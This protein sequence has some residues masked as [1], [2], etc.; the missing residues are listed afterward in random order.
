M[1]D[2]IDDSESVSNPSQKKT[3]SI[4]NNS[5][6]QPFKKRADKSVLCVSQ[7]P[8][9]LNSLNAW[10]FRLNLNE[11]FLEIEI[12]SD[13][14]CENISRSHKPNKNG[15]KKQSK[16]SNDGFGKSGILSEAIGKIM[17][18]KKPTKVW[19]LLHS[20]DADSEDELEEKEV[21]NVVKKSKD[22]S[23]PEGIVVSKRSQRSAAS[24]AIEQMSKDSQDSSDDS[25]QISRK[26]LSRQTVKQS[27]LSSDSSKNSKR[28]ATESSS[29]SIPNEE[30][31]LKAQ[32]KKPQPKSISR[33][34]ENGFSGPGSSYKRQHVK[35]SKL[36]KNTKKK[37]SESA[38]SSDEDFMSKPAM[39]KR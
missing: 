37:S 39:K 3:G 1:N 17:E 10:T 20:H 25:E 15:S 24:K 8:P 30:R 34:Q 22:S 36:Q 26:K 38:E 29:D 28:A 35:V 5:S 32:K 21:S 31:S 18:K 12:Q 14:D 6:Q 16:S 13:S 2:S 27:T 7:T 4:L 33:P 11:K 9:G 19:S 23:E